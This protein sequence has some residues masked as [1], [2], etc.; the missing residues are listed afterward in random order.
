MQTVRCCS[1]LRHGFA[2]KSELDAYLRTAGGGC[3]AGPPKL[4]RELDLF[5][6]RDEAPG[7]TFW[8][9]KGQTAVPNARRVSRGRFKSATGTKKSRRPWIFR[10]QLWETSGHWDHYRENMFIIETEEETMGVKPMNCPAH[11]L[12]YK[13]ETRSYR[14]LPCVTLNT[15]PCRALSF[16]VPCT[17]CCGC[18]ASIK[19]MPI[20]FVREDQIEIGD[21]QRPGPSSTRSTRTSGMEYRSSYRRALRFMGE[22]KRGIGRKRRWHG[23]WS[24]QTYLTR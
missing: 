23:I 16:R 18:G 20:C 11:C 21:R 19:T 17:A 6:F 14:D 10:P 9:P 7:F 1:D 4:G 5:S 2:K 8:H 3:E 24:S 13:R 22:S 12:L 15:A